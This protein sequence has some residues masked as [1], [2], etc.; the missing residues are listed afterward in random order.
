M[1]ESQGAMSIAEGNYDYRVDVNLV[2]DGGQKV[3][4]YI[5][6]TTLDSISVWKAKYLRIPH[7]LPKLLRVLV[8]MLPL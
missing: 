6:R 1:S 7:R 5:L 3:K 2:L 4:K 8:N